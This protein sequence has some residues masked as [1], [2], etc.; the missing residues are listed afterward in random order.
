MSEIPEAD[1]LAAYDRWATHYDADDNPLIAATAWVLAQVPLPVAGARVVE[2]GPWLNV[3]DPGF[4]LH[5][6]RDLIH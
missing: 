1:T 4:N 3:M 2:L 6:R 5:L